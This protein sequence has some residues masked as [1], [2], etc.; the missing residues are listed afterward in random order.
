MSAVTAAIRF[1]TI[2]PAPGGEWSARC[3]QPVR[4]MVPGSGPGDRRRGGGCQLG[5]AACH[6]RHAGRGVS[7]CQPVSFSPARCTSTG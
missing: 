2:V 4:R 5:G 1:L 6:A 3:R 7:P